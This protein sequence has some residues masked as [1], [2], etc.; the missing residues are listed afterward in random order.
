[1]KRNNFASYHTETMIYSHCS[2]LSPT[3]TYFMLHS[4]PQAELLL[5]VKGNASYVID[6][7]IFKLKPQDTILISPDLHHYLCVDDSAEYE[8]YDVMFDLSI[9][10]SSL[11]AL[12]QSDYKVL[13][14]ADSPDALALFYKIDHYIQ[15]Y[16]AEDAGVL[17][18]N[19]VTEILYTLFFENHTAYTGETHQNR[20]LE[21]V[22]QYIQEHLCVIKS[23]EEVCN[24]LFIS[25]SYLHKLFKHYMLITPKKYI[26]QKRLTLARQ[27]ITSG[28][29]PHKVYSV[30]GFEDYTAFFRAYKKFFGTSPTKGKYNFD[31]KTIDS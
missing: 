8:R 19:L 9:L 4:H 6:N 23:I 30:C 11:A 3:D 22:L 29:K 26:V 12:V 15:T 21:E 31:P 17:L 16:P 28:E 5:F 1:M 20:A 18:K 27:M 25:K 13:S 24:E 10:P 2:Y 14:L 7:K